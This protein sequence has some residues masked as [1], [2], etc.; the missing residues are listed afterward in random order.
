MR[1]LAGLPTG[2]ITTFMNCSPSGATGGVGLAIT[3]VGCSYG[4]FARPSAAVCCLAIRPLTLAG[5]YIF[6]RGSAP[7]KLTSASKRTGGRICAYSR[8]NHRLYCR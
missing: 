6:Y 8:L 2:A 4:L 7:P 5:L 3:G 1:G